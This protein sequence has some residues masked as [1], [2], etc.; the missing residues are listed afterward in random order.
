V[1]VP[2]RCERFTSHTLIIDGGGLG[3]VISEPHQKIVLRTVADSQH[4]T[5]TLEKVFLRGLEFTF[6]R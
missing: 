6:P 4:A 1:F 5:Q 3:S 2:Q